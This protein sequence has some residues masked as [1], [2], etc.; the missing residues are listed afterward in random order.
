MGLSDSSRIYHTKVRDLKAIEKDF[1]EY[2]ELNGYEVASEDSL[3]GLFLSITKGG[4]F[5]SVVGLK[6]S[7]NITL[8]TTEDSI[9]V[10][11][12]VGAFGKQ[13]LPSAI[14]LLVA[15]PVLIPQIY[16]MVQQS[17]LDEQAYQIIEQSIRKQEGT[18][19]YQASFGGPDMNVAVGQ[20][21][22][23]TSCGTKVVGDALFCPRCG[24]KLKEELT[25]VKCGAVLPEGTLFCIRCGA[26]QTRE[27]EVTQIKDEEVKP[28]KE[29][30]SIQTID[31]KQ[32]EESKIV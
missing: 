23:C 26:K 32:A 17:K 15:W 31:L 27:S 14:A 12:E 25:C 21:I 6:T 30:E 9:I 13:I 24:K 2:F 4:T 18:V 29:S 16:G 5:Q 10:S 19:P 8:R 11:M 22:F 3:T 7:L 20:S 28:V 1:R